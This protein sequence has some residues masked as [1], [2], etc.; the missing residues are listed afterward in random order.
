MKKIRVLLVACLAAAFM[1]VGAGPAS[2]KCVGEPNVCVLVCEVGTSNK[3]TE[4]LF[5]FCY[6]W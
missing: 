5:E 4:E 2:A 6:V 1:A 3:Y